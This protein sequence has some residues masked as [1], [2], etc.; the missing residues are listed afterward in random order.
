MTARLTKFSDAMSSSFVFCLCVSFRM[1]AKTS[2]SCVLSVSMENSEV[3][4]CVDLLDAAF[5]AASLEPRG[6]E[7]PD[8]LGGLV[9]GREAGADGEDVGVVVLAGE[10]GGL[11]RFDV[12]GADP[13]VL[14][15][16][17]RHADPGT[18]DEDAELGLPG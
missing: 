16:D 1:A 13:L 4:Q 3:G 5:V 18:A 17:D 15:G 9:P 12:R 7:R 8:D 11:H 2:G 6:E 14:V 10:L